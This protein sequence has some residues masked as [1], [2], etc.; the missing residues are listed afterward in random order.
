MPNI[1]FKERSRSNCTP[2]SSGEI[3]TRIEEEVIMSVA[4]VTGE[5][6]GLGF[7]IARGL[8]ALGREVEKIGL[9]K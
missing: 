4:V 9:E 6:H 2:E 8:R 7:E 1:H 3:I 5:S